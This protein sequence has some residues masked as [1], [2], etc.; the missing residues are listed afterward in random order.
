MFP[1][2][3]IIPDSSN[4]SFAEDGSYFRCTLHTHDLI[5]YQTEGK[6]DY[7]YCYEL[8]LKTISMYQ[9]SF[10]TLKIVKERK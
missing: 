7:L 4:D 8:L 5:N 6:A 10:Y 2:H 9:F 1:L 3:F